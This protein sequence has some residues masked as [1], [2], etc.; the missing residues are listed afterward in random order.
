MTEAIAK[1]KEKEQ[2]QNMKKQAG[3]SLYMITILH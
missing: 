2:Q 1:F 3:E